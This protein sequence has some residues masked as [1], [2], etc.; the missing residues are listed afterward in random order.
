MLDTLT[1]GL[2]AGGENHYQRL[3]ARNACHFAPTGGWR[4][5]QRTVADARPVEKPAGR[6]QIAA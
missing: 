6:Y 1:T 3:L 2:G 4:F 5:R